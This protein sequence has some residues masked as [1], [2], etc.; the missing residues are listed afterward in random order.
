MLSDQFIIDILKGKKNGYYVELGGADPI[1][2]SNTYRLEKEYGW[3]G[4]SF[5]WNEEH[6]NKFNEIRENPCLAVDAISFDHGKYFEENNFPERIDYLQVDVD[7]GY[8]ENGH[9]IGNFG[10]NL[11]GLISLPLT[12]YRFS[13]VTFE[14]DANIYFKLNSIRDAQRE[15]MDALGYSLVQRHNWED[16]W[17]DPEIADYMTYRDHFYHGS[18]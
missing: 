8:L 3:K 18:A 5:D 12:R 4:V 6:A 10:S 9:P 17:V 14:H 11:M 2:G 7:T 16:W 15:I 13:I 1:E